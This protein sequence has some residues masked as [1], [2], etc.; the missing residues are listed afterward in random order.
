MRKIHWA[1]SAKRNKPVVKEFQDEYFVRQALLL[2]TSNPRTRVL[3]ESVSVAASFLL[4]M[5]SNDSMLDLICLSE[6]AEILTSGRGT[7]SVNEQ[8]ESLAT[9]THSKLGFEKL[10]ETVLNHMKLI[11]GCILVLSD[12]TEEHQAMIRSLDSAK[13]PQQVFIVTEDESTLIDLPAR[14]HVLPVET[15]QQKLLQLSLA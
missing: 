15:I 12:W 5:N 9:L 11:S 13:I 3:E 8:L 14:F 2:D 1:S 4:A 10:S 7:S 6:K